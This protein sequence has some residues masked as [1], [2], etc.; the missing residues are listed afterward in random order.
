M[1]LPITRDQAYKAV[2]WMKTN[3]HVE[4]AAAVQDTPFS[5]DHICGIGCQ[6]TAYFW[7]SFIDKH[8]VPEVLARCVLDASGDFPDTHRSAFPKN[9]SVFRTRYGDEFTHM[10]IA[11][12]NITRHMRGFGEKNWVYKGYG[13][14][15]YD[16][17][18]VTT[19]QSFFE[20]KKWYHFSD[21][22]SNAMKELKKKWTIH[23]DLWKSIK[24]YNGRGNSA[25]EYA[26]NVIQYTSYSKEVVV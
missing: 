2:S 20:N 18:Y 19:D 12:A 24:A 6:E 25:T 5:I 9:T 16:L 4:I 8:S 1:S 21:C 22:L 26:N 23:N 15:Q 7:L 3:F 14:F 10:L 17:Q 13:L 11:E